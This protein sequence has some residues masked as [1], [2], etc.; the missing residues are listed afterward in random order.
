MFKNSSRAYQIYRKLND[1]EKEILKSK[2]LSGR[3]SIRE[4]YRKLSHIAV[5]DAYADKSRQGLQIILV[6]LAFPAFFIIIFTLNEPGV[7]SFTLLLLIAAL[8]GFTLY[9][10]RTFNRIDI[11]NQLRFF[12]IPM[13]RILSNKVHKKH[14]VDMEIKLALSNDKN[15]LVDEHEDKSPSDLRFLRI[16]TNHYQFP[17]LRVKVPLADGALLSWENEDLVRERILVKQ[18]KGKRKSKHKIKHICR[19]QLML[20][21]S[22]YRLLEPTDEE[23]KIQESQKFYMLNIKG[24]VKTNRHPRSYGDTYKGMRPKYFTA[25]LVKA[26]QQVEPIKPQTA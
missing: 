4:W 2:Q 16:K 1:E 26:Y 13:L 5:M 6:L 20:P 24:K 12:I 22:R 19:I 21:K 18:R 15:F 14:R 3:H 7:V 23:I 8:F 17:W 10:Y 25:L 9:L 11:G